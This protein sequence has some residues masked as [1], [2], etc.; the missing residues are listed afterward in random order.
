MIIA[1][2][3][4]KIEIKIGKINIVYNHPAQNIS[5]FLSCSCIMS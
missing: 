5:K 2:K 4:K 1:H 3:M